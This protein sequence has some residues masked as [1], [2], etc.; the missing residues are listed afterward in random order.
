MIDDQLLA[1][2]ERFEEIVIHYPRMNEIFKRFD[3]LRK[4]ARAVRNLD[5]SDRLNTT[6]LF[7][8]PLI[9]PSGSG[10]SRIINAYMKK[11]LKEQ[12]PPGISPVLVVELSAN[13][14]V[15]GFY[16]DVLKAFGDPNAAKGT[17]QQLEMRTQAFIRKCGVELLIVDEVH[18]L[19]STETNKVRWDVAELFKGILNNKSCCLV[20]SG[21]EN[22]TVLFKSNA[23]LARRCIG[24][25][26]LSPL[27]MQNSTEREMFLGF[28]GQL[29]D[30]MFRAKVT[31][32][33]NGLLEGDM[34][35]CLYEVSEGSLGIVSQITYQALMC[36]LMRGGT[37]LER[38]DFAKGT[39][40]WALEY[41]ISTSNPFRKG[42]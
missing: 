11:V 12:H 17:Q 2:L 18:H 30:R 38:C 34:P 13:V 20:L 28:I 14:T 31:D 15:K 33:R 25:V 19:I 26:S 42:A 29:D 36:C 23:Q 10:K 39:D 5:P 8:L 37:V 24:P 35:A 27:D 22:A 32:E 4:K 3:F 16:A 41:G 1:R 40:S 21:V 9:A 6:S 7:A